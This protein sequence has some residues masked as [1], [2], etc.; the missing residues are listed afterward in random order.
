MKHKTNINIKLTIA[1]KQ[2]LRANKLKIADILDFAVDELEVMLD[3]PFE[4]A[5]EIAALTQF[6][7]IPSVG[8]K[9]AEDLIFMGYYSIPEL[10]GKNGAKLIDEYEM[11]KGYWVDP[12]VEDQFRL[13]VHYAENKDNTLKWSDFTDERKKYRHENGYPANRPKTAWHETF[14]FEHPNVKTAG[15]KNIRPH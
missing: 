9:F 14:G 5:R 15:F 4:R 10:S 12:C 2:K 3:V 7:T 13:V 1:E 8:L 6:Q 11:K